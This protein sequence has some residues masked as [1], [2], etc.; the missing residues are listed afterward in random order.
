LTSHALKKASL[1][2]CEIFLPDVPAAIPV[3]LQV[4][5]ST[6]QSMNPDVFLSGL[7]FLV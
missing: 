7:R 3:L 4:R 6:K 1:V 5:W 2:R